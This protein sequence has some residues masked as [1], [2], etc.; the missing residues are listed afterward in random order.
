MTTAPQGAT[1]P[2]PWRIE[3]SFPLPDTAQL[4]VAGEVDLTTAPT[5][6]TRLRT[7]MDAHHPA[8]VYL[9]L[10]E[11]TFLDCAGVGMLVAVR[12][13]ADH[14][15]CQIRVSHPRPIVARV[16]TMVGLLELLTAPTA[17]VEPRPSPVSSAT[18]RTRVS[19]VAR[20]VI[21]RIAA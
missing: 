18:A 11:V 6:G 10:A 20:A 16:L 2:A 19:R 21:R 12:S 15:G 13:T 14:N 17:S 4:S 5:L 8:V 1:V 9:D 7:V 3:V